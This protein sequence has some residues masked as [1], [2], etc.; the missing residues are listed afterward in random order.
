MCDYK[1]VIDLATLLNVKI[2]PISGFN[3][4]EERSKIYQLY[5]EYT[6]GKF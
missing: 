1:K 3:F 4:Y 5:A 2:Y 6:G